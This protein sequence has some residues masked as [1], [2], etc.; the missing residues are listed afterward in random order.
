MENIE[1]KIIRNKINSIENLP[2]DYAASLDSKFEL[3]LTGISAK[4][5]KRKKIWVVIPWGVAAGIAVLIVLN[6]ISSDK[7]NITRQDKAAVL[8]HI[9]SQNS[10]HHR[11][12]IKIE[13]QKESVVISNLP[14]K[15]IKTIDSFSRSEKNVI[16]IDPPK[17]IESPILQIPSDSISNTVT[18]IN[19]K[20]VQIKVKRHRFAEID[21]NDNSNTESRAS[22][23]TAK[24]IKIDFQ[25]NL[26]S[27]VVP[28]PAVMP[29]HFYN[30]F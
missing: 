29:L 27:N 16:V 24:K 14:S 7:K 28:T 4:S 5:K 3:L 23:S 15:N 30:Q 8:Q 17:R 1:N 20:S 19:E 2:K 6:Q 21:F 11:F 12:A 18:V 26:T 9:S 22:E 13:P 10:N 25:L